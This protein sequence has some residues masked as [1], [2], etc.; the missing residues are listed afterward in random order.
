MSGSLNFNLPEDIEDA[1]TEAGND[2]ADTVTDIIDPIELPQPADVIDTAAIDVSDL[3]D[4]IADLPAPQAVADFFAN[5]DDLNFARLEGLLD[6]LP[7]E[8]RGPDSTG[9][10]PT[11]LSDFLQLQVEIGAALTAT[12]RVVHT[13]G[14]DAIAMQVRGFDFAIN[15]QYNDNESGFSAIRVL[16]A[17]GGPVVFV[18]DG[19]EVGSIADTVAAV[20]LGGLQVRS[21]AFQ[22]MIAD[23]V[24]AQ[25]TLGRGVQ[26]VGPSLGGAVAQVAAYEATEAMLAAGVSIAPGAVRLLTVDPLGGRD[27]AEKLNGGSLDPNVLS[28]INALNIRTEGDLITRIGSH[29]G[30]TVSFQAV[31]ANGNPIAVTAADAHVNVTSL[32]RTLPDATLYN[33]GVRG[34]P[35]EVSGFA[36]V[37]NALGQTI[38]DGYLASGERDDP[39]ALVELQ[40][41]GQA[42]L[43]NNNTLYRLDADSNGTLDLA[44]LTSQPVSQAVADLV[45]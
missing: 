14:P 5:L 34:A 6:Q 22:A 36:L 10:V 39:N 33:A 24:E 25:V 40:V 38:A 23:A 15:E 13:L 2:V 21:A 45:L 32:L 1:L 7:P 4:E 30:E 31:D 43:L 42:E 11:G 35:E 18:I 37:A 3:I 28:Y 20:D 9:E 19:L 16:P 44:V 41:P 8:Y 27:A 26:F 29:I 12:A 17:D